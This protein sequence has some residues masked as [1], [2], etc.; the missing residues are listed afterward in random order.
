MYS[1]LFNLYLYFVVVLYNYINGISS[2]K[3]NA[4]S[5]IIHEYNNSIV[6][7][8]EYDY[9]LHKHIRNWL[10]DPKLHKDK[11]I[12]NKVLIIDNKKTHKWNLY[13]NNVI[14]YKNNK[15]NV[16]DEYNLINH[17]NDIK[18]DTNYLK[19]KIKWIKHITID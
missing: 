2:Y 3:K 14:S 16:I 17:I 11:D 8:Y 4:L 1:F 5:L 18:L 6:Y 15:L 12:R 9:T 19:T 7:E 13:I 10:D